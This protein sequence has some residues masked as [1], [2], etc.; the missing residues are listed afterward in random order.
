MLLPPKK[1]YF[2]NT[3]HFLPSASISHLLRHFEIDCGYVSSQINL[4]VGRHYI[5][6]HKID[7]YCRRC[8]LW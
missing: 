8:S 1:N 3:L 7:K 4:V 6:G 2:Q 5:M